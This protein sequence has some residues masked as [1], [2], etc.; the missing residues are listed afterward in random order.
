MHV[1][2]DDPERYRYFLTLKADRRGRL[3][4]PGRAPGRRSRPGRGGGT[5][6]GAV[7]AEPRP[8]PARSGTG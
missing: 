6:D 5:G 4:G 2:L 1:V 8:V 3:L 7:P